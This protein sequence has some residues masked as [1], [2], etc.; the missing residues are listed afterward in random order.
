MIF[1]ILA[2]LAQIFGCDRSNL[3]NVV[4][5]NISSRH[6]IRLYSICAD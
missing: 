4:A 2:V 5:A 3:I 1:R 6:I